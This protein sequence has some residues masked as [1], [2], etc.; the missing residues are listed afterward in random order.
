[1]VAGATMSEPSIGDLK[2]NEYQI[3]GG[4]PN[5]WHSITLK[6][7]PQLKGNDKWAVYRDGSVLDKD[8]DW[9]YEPLPS[10]RDDKYLRHHRFDSAEKALA[11][12]S[13]CKAKA[14][15]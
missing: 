9:V 7:M 12:Y 6:R 5:D 3:E 15:P 1:M 14:Q 13:K 4:G 2:V 10:S 8:G 11:F